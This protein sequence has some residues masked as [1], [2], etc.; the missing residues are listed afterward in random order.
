M[1]NWSFFNNKKHHGISAPECCLSCRRDSV[2]TNARSGVRALC[3]WDRWA[4]SVWVVGFVPN[5]LSINIRI[6]RW[7][8]LV[9]AQWRSVGGEASTDDIDASYST[10]SYSD[11]FT[12]VSVY[13]FLISIILNLFFS[14]IIQIYIIIFVAFSGLFIS[15]FLLFTALQPLWSSRPKLSVFQM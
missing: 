14:S 4:V 15:F 9:S 10:S 11:F 13:V 5:Y 3:P 2:E 1:Q 8:R 12:T 7:G 6:V